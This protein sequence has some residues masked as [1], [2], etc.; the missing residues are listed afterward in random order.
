MSDESFDDSSVSQ[1]QQILKVTP[2]RSLINVALIL[3]MTSVSLGAQHAKVAH[4]KANLPGL[5]IT[6]EKVG[7]LQSPDIAE[8]KE[9]IWLRLHNN[10]RWSIR[11]D[12]GGVPA[13]YGDARLFFDRLLDG[14]VIFRETCHA[15]STNLVGPGK[16]IL[17]NVSRRDL[18]KRHAI[19]I[20]FS[21]GWEKW[22]D[23][24][25]GREPEH[26]VY[27]YASQIPR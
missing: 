22:D 3:M 27:F 8:D 16:S 26:Y 1:E 25:A 11:L 9:R 2:M 23:V 6:F 17:F 15:C 4:I 24:I 10:T 21:Y 20:K 5:Y 19:R 18:G 7:E 13:E 12:M 14:E